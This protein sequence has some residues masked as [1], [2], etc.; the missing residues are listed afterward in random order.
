M[1]KAKA[2]LLTALAGIGAIGLFGP[3]AL[4]R[5]SPYAGAEL[6]FWD[7]GAQRAAASVA[8]E[9]QDAQRAM[10]FGRRAVEA[11]PY[12]QF[13]LA[14]GSLTV[15]PENRLAA[16]NLS[17]ALGWRDLATNVQLVEAALREGAPVIAAQR[18][19]ALGRTQG[20]EVAGPL[21]DRLLLM[22]G[23]IDA[24]ADRAAMRN[25]RNWWEQWL[26]QPPA[27]AQVADSRKQ[28]IARFDKSDGAWLRGIVGAASKGMAEAGIADDGFTIWRSA[29]AD[30]ALFS[31]LIYDGEFTQFGHGARA[32]GGE[33]V[34]GAK[35][36]ASVERASDGGVVVTAGQQGSGPVLAQ[37]VAL[38]AGAAVLSVKGELERGKPSGFEWQ[39]RCTGGAPL[40]LQA[41]DGAQ[42]AIGRWSVSIPASCADGNLLLS[43]RVGSGEALLRIRQVE[44]DS[45]P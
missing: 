14:L 17:A 6:G 25:S 43:R 37:R 4:A 15:S 45:R 21:A 16:L 33:W 3:G 12:E 38:A 27:N 40:A 30:P 8:F 41:L 35:G 18:I 9:Q 1:G 19:D 2:A 28:L 11:M 7:N 5:F 32:I 42:G 20:P 24:L 23:G 13:G 29:I 34:V 44:L 31:G 26:L 39:L 36:G 10:R 22:Q